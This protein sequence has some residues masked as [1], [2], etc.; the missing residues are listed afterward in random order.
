MRLRIAP[1]SDGKIAVSPSNPHYRRAGD[2]GEDEACLHRT[3]AACGSF[4]APRRGRIDDRAYFAGLYQLSR[5]SCSFLAGG[6]R[7]IGAVDHVGRFDPGLVLEVRRAARQ[8]L[9]GRAD[10]RLALLA[11]G[12]E[13][14]GQR[15]LHLH[16]RR[17]QAEEAR[18]RVGVDGGEFRRGD[19]GQEGLGRIGI[20]ALGVEADA[21]VGVVGDV[22]GVAGLLHR[23]R[24][25]A[26]LELRLR[27][28]AGDLPRAGRIDGG[29][30]ER[31]QVLAVRIGLRLEAVAEIGLPLGERRD[32]ARPTA[33]RS[34]S[35]RP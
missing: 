15:I 3:S 1:A 20:R 29:A 30:A 4:A 33:D 2:E 24:E 9:V 28:E 8:D 10:R 27:V 5:P 25:G 16:R 21:D 31:E 7:R 11:P 19:P 18:Q 13:F 34:A 6:F 23:R 26:H 35:A 32:R 22:A 17:G 14:L 12:D